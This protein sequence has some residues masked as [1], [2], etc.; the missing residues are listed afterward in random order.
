VPVSSTPNSGSPAI[1]QLGVQYASAL[2]PPSGTAKV[3]LHTYRGLWIA[4]ALIAI[5]AGVIIALAVR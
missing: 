3:V 5:M 4:L 1:G 2:R